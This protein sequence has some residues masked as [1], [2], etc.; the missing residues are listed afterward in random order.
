MT[1][2]HGETRHP[3]YRAIILSQDLCLPSVFIHPG[4]SIAG[5]DPS[6]ADRLIVYIGKKSW[7]GDRMFNFVVQ[8]LAV[9]G[10]CVH[11][12]GRVGGEKE[13]TPA[14]SG[15]VPSMSEYRHQITPS[16]Y[17]YRTC[18]HVARCLTSCFMISTASLHS[19]TKLIKDSSNFCPPSPK[20]PDQALQDVL[21]NY[22]AV[23]ASVVPKGA[24]FSKNV[25]IDS[26]CIAT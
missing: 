4:E 23:I 10:R 2:I 11:R 25:R 7:R 16:G 9:V 8:S 19:P 17:C 24:R 26:P 5:S 15:V 13:A 6:P 12:P 18:F 3:P 20:L 1:A 22:E 21:S 14:P